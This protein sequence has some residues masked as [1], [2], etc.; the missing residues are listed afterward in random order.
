[1]IFCQRVLKNFSASFHLF[2]F[3]SSESAICAFITWRLALLQMCTIQ[4][5]SS[6]F[7][8]LRCNLLFMLLKLFRFSGRTATSQTG[9]KLREYNRKQTFWFKFCKYVKIWKLLGEIVCLSHLE[10]YYQI[11]KLSK[12]VPAN[13]GRK[14][15]KNSKLRSLD[16]IC[17]DVVKDPL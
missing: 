11:E 17:D 1:M 12:K 9:K 2:F 6:G 3:K 7:N 14:L 8:V 10:A 16:R 5:I 15:L 4:K 13:A